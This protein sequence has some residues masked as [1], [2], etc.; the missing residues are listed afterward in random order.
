MACETFLLPIKLLNNLGLAACG[1]SDKTC[2]PRAVT[3]LRDD[4]SCTG[5]C[6]ESNSFSSARFLFLELVKDLEMLVRVLVW[7]LAA[8][9]WLLLNGLWF[10][11]NLLKSTLI[12]FNFV[13]LISFTNLVCR[14]FVICNSL[15]LFSCLRL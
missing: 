9:D 2:I 7:D 12:Y 15:I 3:S 4:K 10:F 6:D 11:Y 14:T 13:L 5:V 1:V 8:E